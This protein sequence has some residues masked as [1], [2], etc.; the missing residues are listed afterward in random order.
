MQRMLSMVL[1]LTLAGASFATSVPPEIKTVVGFVFVP[2]ALGQPVANGTCFFASVKDNDHP[3]RLWIYV[4][5]AK[6]VLQ[7]NGTFYPRV[8]IRIN[9][10]AGGTES[11]E[12]PLAVSGANRTLFLHSDATVDLAV[13][14]IRIADP[15]AFD[16]KVLTEDMLTSQD[17]FEKLAIRE[18]SDVFFTGMFLPHIGANKNYPIMRFGRVALLSDEKIS[19]EGILTDLYLIETFSFGGNSGSPVFFYL[20]SDRQPGSIIAGPPVLKLAGVMKGYFGELEPIA[21]IDTRPVP[22]SKLNSGIAAVTPAY[23]LHDILYAA[24]LER[25]RSGRK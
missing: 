17:D 19:W 14:P 22:A 2:N 5:T 18:G 7:Q 9:K 6:H 16:L 10:K 25:L 23:K 11:F 3:G 13:V 20:G 15:A 8:W 1:V 24:E 21:V 12:L 4:V